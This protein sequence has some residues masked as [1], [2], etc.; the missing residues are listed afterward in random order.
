MLL[1]SSHWSTAWLV[2]IPAHPEGGQPTVKCRAS[3]WLTSSGVTHLG[4]GIPRDAP[5]AW[6]CVWEPCDCTRLLCEN[7]KRRAI[8]EPGRR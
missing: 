6:D 2:L 5:S 4:I 1:V 3:D 7:T 8:I